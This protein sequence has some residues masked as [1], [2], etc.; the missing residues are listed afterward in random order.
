MCLFF[1]I[2]IFKLAIFPLAPPIR[3]IGYFHNFHLG[4][5][6]VYELFVGKTQIID[7]GHDFIKLYKNTMN[8]S[9]IRFYEAMYHNGQKV[10][11]LRDFYNY[12]ISG[13]KT[14]GKKKPN[15]QKRKIQVEERPTKPT[16]PMKKKPN[17]FFPSIEPMQSETPLSSISE[18]EE[19]DN[20]K[21]EEK[22]SS[23]PTKEEEVSLSDHNK[24]QSHKP[25]KR[26]DTHKGTL[27]S[28]QDKIE[29]CL[30]HK[31]QFP[32]PSPNSKTPKEED[33]V[34]I[35]EKIRLLEEKLNKK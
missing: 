31:A 30:V 17:M 25:C 32:S 1:V 14:V 21:S 19:E 9:R 6:V 8:A 27:Q 5:C 33:Y 29:E 15:P 16:Q 12:F 4:Y 10:Q 11:E 3:Q 34:R 24:T 20:D 13:G 2:C 7:L 23:S 28:F 35:K 22:A 26:E 18:E